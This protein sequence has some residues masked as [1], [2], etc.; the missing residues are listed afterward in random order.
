M[1]RHE[2]A[3]FGALA[4]FAA[5]ELYRH[6]ATPEQKRRWEGFVKVHHGTVGVVAAATGALAGSPTIA[7]AGLGLAI[8]DARDA[9]KWFESSA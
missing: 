3:M 5:G 4:A 7:G 1:K 6:L 8:H 2:K 9:P